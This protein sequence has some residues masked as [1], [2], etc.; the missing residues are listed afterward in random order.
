M[1][2][3]VWLTFIC[4]DLILCKE[5]EI[6]DTPFDLVLVLELRHDSTPALCVQFGQDVAVEY[7]DVHHFS[8]QLRDGRSTEVRKVLGFNSRPSG[9]R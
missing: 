5:K 7:L 9:N 8:L 4:K 1:P 2:L 6:T 3:R